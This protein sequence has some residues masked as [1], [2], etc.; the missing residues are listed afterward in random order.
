[1]CEYLLSVG[2]KIDAMNDQGKTALDL[3]RAAQ[4]RGKFKKLCVQTIEVL[5][6]AAAAKG[7]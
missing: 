6:K 2:A 3:A 7:K 4:K 1:M 5:Q